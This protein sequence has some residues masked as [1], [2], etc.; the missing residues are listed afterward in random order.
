MEKSYHEYT[1]EEVALITRIRVFFTLRW[2]VVAGTI[3][4]TLIAT[5]IFHIVFPVLPIYIIC[6]VIALY[7]LVLW[8][9]LRNLARKKHVHVIQTTREIGNLHFFLDLIALAGIL[10][11]SGGIENPF[12]FYF[13]L[14]II[15]ASIVLNYR[16]A[17]LLGTTAVLIA[18]TLVGLEY[19]NIVPHVN[20]QGF[21]SPNLYHELGYIIAILVTLTTLIYGSIFMVTA[22][23]GELR[24]RQREVMSLR[25]RLIEQKTS[26]LERA[27]KEIIKLE[28]EKKRFLL[29]LSVAAH[30]LKAPLTAIQGY[31]WVMLGGYS[32]ELNEKQQGMMERSSLR[33]KELLNLISNLLDIPRIE[34][35]QIIQEM[36]DVSLL[37]IITTSVEDL[38]QIAEDKGLTIIMQL[39]K[40]LPK[41]NCADA[42]I[43][44]VMLNLLDNAIRYTQEGSITVKV[45]EHDKK[46]KV[47]VMDTGLGIPKEDIPKLFQD[48]FRASNT[49]S[50]GTGLGLA[51]SRR[52]IEAH[53]GEIWVESPCSENKCGSNFAFT[54]PIK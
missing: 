46:I 48:F 49:E 30:D 44:Q 41:I 27:T 50:K 4:A 12:I 24:K 18:I 36:K 47:E 19:F 51:I 34:T 8:L 11:F 54:L 2:Y 31:L 14:H 43:K 7:N 40:K 13:V 37:D 5:Y 15:A 33:I 53:N 39:P 1:P 9:Q 35:G 22:I 17:Y 21:A 29:F 6:V 10:H 25:E 16:A 45:S 38:R 23:S 3:V 42:R 26:E 28:E 20:L 52:I 32:G